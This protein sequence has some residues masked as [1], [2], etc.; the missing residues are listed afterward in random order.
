MEPTRAAPSSDVGDA[1]ALNAALVDTLSVGLLMLNDGSRGECE[2]GAEYY[3][4]DFHE[5]RLQT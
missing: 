1:A 5:D 3:E 2:H 4:F